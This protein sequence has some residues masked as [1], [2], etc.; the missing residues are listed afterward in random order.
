LNILKDHTS[1]FI[2]TKPAMGE[3]RQDV[4]ERIGKQS[5]DT[6]INLAYI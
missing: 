4:E 1:L 6:A 5:T 3:I 2:G